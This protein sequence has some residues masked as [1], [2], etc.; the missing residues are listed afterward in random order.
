MGSPQLRDVAEMRKL[1][2]ERGARGPTGLGNHR[3]RS[4]ERS[5]ERSI[6]FEKKE[7]GRANQRRCGAGVGGSTAEA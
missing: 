1:R 6:E 7:T 5:L 4:L 3:V 2:P